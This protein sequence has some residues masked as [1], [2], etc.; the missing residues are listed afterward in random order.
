LHIFSKICYYTKFYNC[1]VSGRNV[2]P[3][4]EIH[5]ATILVLLMDMELQSKKIGW[6]PMVWPLYQVYWKSV[7]CFKSY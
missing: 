5:A 3:I 2:T 4:L 7:N 6:S 1:T